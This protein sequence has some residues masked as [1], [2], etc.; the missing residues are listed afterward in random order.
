M[1]A[2]SDAPAPPERKDNPSNAETLPFVYNNPGEN[3]VNQ[4]C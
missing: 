2:T 1:T 4:K 3:W